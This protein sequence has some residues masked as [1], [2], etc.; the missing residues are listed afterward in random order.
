[1]VP[2]VLPPQL[3][4]LSTTIPL[5]LAFIAGAG[6]LSPRVMLI[7]WAECGCASG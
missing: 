4:N 7:E 1:M 6:C 5:A 3:L 2:L